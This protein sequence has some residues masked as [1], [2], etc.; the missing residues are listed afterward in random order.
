MQFL[1]TLGLEITD[2]SKVNT[3]TYCSF[4]A[5][6]DRLP[7]SHFVVR[8]LFNIQ[9][10]LSRQALDADQYLSGFASELKTRIS[11]RFPNCGTGNL[12]HS[13]AHFLD[14]R[15]KGVILKQFDGVFEETVYFLKNLSKK[16]VKESS[17]PVNAEELNNAGVLEDEVLE[18]SSLSAAERLLKTNQQTSQSRRPSCGIERELDNYISIQ[19]DASEASN[20]NPLVFWKK[21]YGS[22]YLLSQCAREVFSVP[23]SSAT[24]ERAFSVG[25]SVSF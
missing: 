8:E 17:E 16:Y 9:D 6:G 1:S 4:R 25:G 21:N 5:Q 22:F 19:I 20:D 12:V 7:T 15:F 18:D 13:A 11:N 10:V 24:S 14:P 3:L 23:A 2:Q